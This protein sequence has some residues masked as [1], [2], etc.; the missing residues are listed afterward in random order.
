VTQPTDAM[1]EAMR[2]AHLGWSPVGEDRSVVTLEARAAELCGTEEAVFLPTGAMANVVALC[3]HTTPGTQAIVESASHILWS[4]ES[5]LA[6]VCGLMV[7]SLQGRKGILEPA[8]VEAAI[9][10]ERA[11]HH[12]RTGIVCLENTHNFA[13]GT[14]ATAAA[15]SA[16][17]ATAHAHG[18]P[19][20]LDGSRVWN[21]CVALNT[22]LSKLVGDVDSVSVGLN[23]G[24]SAPA[25]SL[26]CGSRRFVDAARMHARR[27]GGA[28]IPQA[29]ILA[30]AGIVAVE[31]M[32][33]RLADDHRRAALLAERLAGTE[34][35]LLDPTQV[36]TN[37]VMLKLSPAAS[38]AQELCAALRARGI[39][40]FPYLEQQIR[41]VT[42]RHISDASI[43]RLAGAIAAQ[44]RRSD[45]NRRDWRLPK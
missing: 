30:A 1:W 18:V 26:L 4:E 44:L 12:P 6:A 39:G 28:S 33:A 43:D 42:H 35:V 19:V 2:S 13:G 7:R 31:S 21:A 25:G 45:L 32:V 29:G 9:V 36:Q 14:V 40:A 8:A 11:G 41:L 22:D 20:H 38:S 16:V 17:C 10:D 23:K 5:G 24:L 34:G 3:A 15:V 37:I 27:L